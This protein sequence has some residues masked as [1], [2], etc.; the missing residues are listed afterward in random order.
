MKSEKLEEEKMMGCDE[1]VEIHTNSSL[2]RYGTS[3]VAGLPR[4]TPSLSS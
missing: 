2:A 4:S 3:K 1:C